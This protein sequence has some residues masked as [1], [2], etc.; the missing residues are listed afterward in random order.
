MKESDIRP[1]ALYKK[2]LE[3]SQKDAENCFGGE[4]RKDIPCVACG[5]EDS[6]RAFSKLGFQYVQCKA[7]G[8]LYQSPRAS[9][10]AFEAFYRDSESSN[11]WANV[12][13]PAIAEVRR[14]RIFRPRVERLSSIVKKQ[15][16]EVKRII[17]VGAGFGIF[18]DEWRAHHDEGSL[19]AVE[20]SN[21][22]AAECRAKGFETCESIVE[23]VTGFDGFADLVV[24]FEVLEH[25]FSPLEF[26]KHLKR[27]TRP[28]GIVFLSTL[29]VDGFDLQLLWDRSNQIFPPHH[30]NFLSV[31]GF[32]LLFEQAGLVDVSVTTPGQLDVDIVSKA[33]RE[34]P[35]ILE[36]QRFLKNILRDS[37]RANAF[38]K[39]LAENELSSHAWVYGRVPC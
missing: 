17:D 39:F 31:E 21:S 35:S 29:S 8:T 22:L 4:E 20:P 10:S 9:L 32:R 19:I 23:D 28:G 25:V 36:E 37:S 11:Y 7:C 2:Y 18:L 30:I 13:F 1:E 6:N 38:Q 16:L 15:G 3:L 34:N 26:V 12:F 5:G 24:C 27:L 14:E 33:Y